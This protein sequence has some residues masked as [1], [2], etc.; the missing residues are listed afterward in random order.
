MAH[1]QHHVRQRKQRSNVTQTTAIESVS[2]DN[3]TILQ[4]Q[5]SPKRHHQMA[6]ETREEKTSA[7]SS[8]RDAVSV[9]IGL[10][11]MVILAYLHT[12]YMHTLHENYLWFSQIKVILQYMLKK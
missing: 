4:E 12:N 3:E 5:S 10:T 1:E 11:G 7:L 6:E 2:S 9:M 8:F